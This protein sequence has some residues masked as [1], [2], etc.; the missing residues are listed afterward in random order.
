MEGRS[1]DLLGWGWGWWGGGGG[2]TKS[3]HSDV[4]NTVLSRGQS[5]W[6]SLRVE[7]EQAPLNTTEVIGSS[8]TSPSDGSPPTM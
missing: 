8:V 1:G 3:R 4:A 6:C 2:L 5:K 7:S